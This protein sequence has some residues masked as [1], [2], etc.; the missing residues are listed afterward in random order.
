MTDTE[1]ANPSR[2]VASVVEDV[3]KIED[4]PKRAADA[5]TE[6]NPKK[7]LAELEWQIDDLKEKIETSL[8]KLNGRRRR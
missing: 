5:A 4:V 8:A 7:Q 6:P 2:E 3:P 1:V